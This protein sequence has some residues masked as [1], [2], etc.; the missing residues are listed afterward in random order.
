MTVEIVDVLDPPS[1]VT[2]A[3]LDGYRVRPCVLHP[4][5]VVEYPC[6]N[7]LPRD[8]GRMIE[9]WDAGRPDGEPTY[10]QVS[11]AGGWKVGGYAH[12]DGDYVAHNCPQ[13]TQP[14][15]LLLTVDPAE[16]RFNIWEPVEERDRP[17]PDYLEPTGVGVRVRLF[18]CDHCSGTPFGIQ[19]QA[20]EDYT[21]I[22]A[23]LDL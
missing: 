16:P 15:P 11:Q 3:V 20:G 10:V 5:Q 12:W 23:S 9:E 1:L 2:A 8:L 6:V 7:E 21:G 13:C 19:L 17:Q 18:A 4:E 14:M 22:A